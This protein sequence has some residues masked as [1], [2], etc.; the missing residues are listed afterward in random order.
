M[1]VSLL[2]K[3]WWGLDNSNGLWQ[4]I[5]KFKYLK[6]KSICTV[7]HR[8]NDSPI[9]ADLLK[10]KNVYLQGRK[11]VIRDGKKTM[12]WKDIWMHDKPLCIIYPD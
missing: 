7:K 12:L 4:E 11:I 3:W 5:V 9:W 6:D 8:Q 2:C 10:I 1:N